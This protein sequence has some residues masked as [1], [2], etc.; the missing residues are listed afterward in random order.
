MVRGAGLAGPGPAG[1]DPA[2]REIHTFIDLDLQLET[3]RIASIHS[4]YLRT[5]GIDNL[6]ILVARTQNGEIAAYVGSQGYFDVDRNGFVDGVVA[7]RSSGSILKPFLYGLAIDEG[8]IA[9]DTM[10][11]DI[12]THFGAFFPR[13]VGLIHYGMLPAREA[14][15]HSLNVPAVRILDEYGVADF[16]FALEG[17]GISTLFRSPADY[18]LTLIIGGAETSLIDLVALY[19]VFGNEGV[20]APLRLH[21]STVRSPPTTERRVLSEGSAFLVL[22]MLKDLRRPGDESWWRRRSDSAALAWKTGTSFGNRDA[23]AVGVSPEWTIGVWVGN[24]TGEE[25]ANL[26]STATSAPL[27]FDVWSL[28]SRDAE[29]FDPP[30][31]ALRELEFCLDTGYPA[32]D[33]C[34]NSGPA[35]IPVG[36]KMLPI[37]PYHRR[38]HLDENGHEVNSLCWEGHEVRIES[39]LYYPAEAVQYLVGRGAAI[40]QPPQLNLDCPDLAS[41]ATYSSPSDV[42]SILYPRAGA[43]LYL[44]RDLDGELQ[45]V[46]LK[47]AHRSPDTRI[48]WYIDG[49]YLGQ[50]AT[51]HAIASTISPGEHTLLIVDERGEKSSTNFRVWSG[52]EEN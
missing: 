11:I 12:P 27:L 35:K 10:I 3:E 25:N 30:V 39:R 6:S 34:E 46:N 40:E 19:R 28:V 7:P 47:A 36:A 23:W 14:L 38:V 21:D 15:A 1:P 9:P 26:T 16:H 4:E 18:G 51:D 5:L 20:F 31:T 33:A 41:V 13:N 17:A 22:D 44:P 29:W 8:I 42:L 24:F 49:I 48:F 2:G 37:C 32:G 52:D 43:R 45:A 50:T